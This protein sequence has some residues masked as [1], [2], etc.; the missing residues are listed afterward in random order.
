MFLSG[1]MGTQSCL[2]VS[3]AFNAEAQVKSSEAPCCLRIRS[4]LLEL[5]INWR[6]CS[7]IFLNETSLLSPNQSL[8]AKRPDI[9]LFCAVPFTYSDNLHASPQQQHASLEAVTHDSFKAAIGGESLVAH[10]QVHCKSISLVS[11]SLE[12]RNHDT[13]SPARGY[14]TAVWFHI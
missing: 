8:R 9:N 14:E 13:P 10:H 1:L 2:C 5:C 7:Q 3:L 4:A 12:G 6:L 11:C